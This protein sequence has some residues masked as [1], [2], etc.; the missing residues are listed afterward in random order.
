M[1]WGELLNYRDPYHKEAGLLFQAS[2]EKWTT[3]KIV[4]KIQNNPP[5]PQDGIDTWYLQV[6]ESGLSETGDSLSETLCHVRPG[7]SDAWLRCW[8]RAILIQPTATWPGGLLSLFSFVAIN[9]GLGEWPL[10]FHF[11]STPSLHSEPCGLVCLCRR[12]SM[13]I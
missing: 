9:I 11:P 12:V 1:L 3:W 8:E 4:K 2:L 5:K 13:P 7:E 10:F 6:S